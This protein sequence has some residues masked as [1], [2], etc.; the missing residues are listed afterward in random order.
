MTQKLTVSNMWDIF[1]CYL[2]P[3]GT[4]HLSLFCCVDFRWHDTNFII[5]RP[6]IISNHLP[7]LLS[8]P[9]ELITYQ[10]GSFDSEELPEHIQ[11]FSPVHRCFFKG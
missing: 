10:I 1:I 4:L 9:H 2:H 5:Y 3:L 8:N 11:Y 6:K 7:I